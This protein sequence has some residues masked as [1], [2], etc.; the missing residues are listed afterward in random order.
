MG[1]YDRVHL[2][3]GDG[4]AMTRR[5]RAA[6]RVVEQ[7][8]NDQFSVY[9]GSWQSD[10]SASGTTHAGA[11]V[12]DIWLPGMGNNDRTL[13]VTRKLRRIGG[14]AAMLRGPEPYG[15]YVW[16]WHI[17]DLD[18]HDMSPAGKWQVVQYRDGKE[19][20]SSS[21][22]GPDPVPYRPNPIRAFDWDEHKKLVVANRRIDNLEDKI[23]DHQETIEDLRRERA[24]WQRQKRQLLR[25]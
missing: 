6:L 1:Q 20:I 2:N 16:H 15:G 5:Q 8:I 9:Q 25:H 14:Q 19:A 3:V 18:T 21:E 11:G 23:D 24:R 17:M 13:S 12:I 10:V 4:E 7:E 22:N